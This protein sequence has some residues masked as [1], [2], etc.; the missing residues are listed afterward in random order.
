MSMIARYISLDDNE[1]AHLTDGTVM[2][3]EFVSALVDNEER[4][5]DI[6]KAWAGIHM[7]LCGKAWEGEL[8]LFNAVLGGKPLGDEDLGYGP[9]RYLSA[10]EVRELSLALSGI[11]LLERRDAFME[12]VHGNDEVYPGFH[13]EEDLNYLDYN[14]ARLKEFLCDCVG[15]GKNLLLFL[16]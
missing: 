7:L 2:V 3:E 12:L 1:L 4:C 15:N 13:D 16:G 11:D 14:F 6:D 10:Q 9:A 8:P 5:L